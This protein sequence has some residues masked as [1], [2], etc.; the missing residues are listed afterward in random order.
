M[1]VHYTVSPEQEEQRRLQRIVRFLTIATV[2]VLK[3]QSRLEEGDVPNAERDPY[4]LQKVAWAGGE[5]PWERLYTGDK[6]SKQRFCYHCGDPG[7]LRP[8]CQQLHRSRPELSYDLPMLPTKK[9]G[10]G[11]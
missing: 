10:G 1:P 3:L 6:K 11:N 7:H 9:D 8:S 2:D 5:A 4:W